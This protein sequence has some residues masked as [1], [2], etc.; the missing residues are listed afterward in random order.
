MRKRG[1]PCPVTKVT[2]TVVFDVRV[3]VVMTVVFMVCSTVLRRILLGSSQVYEAEKSIVVWTETLE[4]GTM[5][6]L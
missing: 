6:V 5:T 2:T 1:V 3:V 4:K